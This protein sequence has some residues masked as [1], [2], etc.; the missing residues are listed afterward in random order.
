MPGMTTRLL[1]IAT[2]SENVSISGVPLV[3]TVPAFPTRY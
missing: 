2:L 3:K 1:D